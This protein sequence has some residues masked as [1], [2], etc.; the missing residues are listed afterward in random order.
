M[1]ALGTADGRN[2]LDDLFALDLALVADTATARRGSLGTAA[3]VASLRRLSDG[4][5]HAAALA[6]LLGVPVR[7]VLSEPAAARRGALTTPGARPDA[8]VVDLGAGTVDVIAVH[9]EVVAAGAGE[10]LT[11]A[12][13]ETLR[14]PRAAADWVKRGPCVRVDGGRRFEAEDGSRGFLDRPA[15]AAAAG[16]LAARGPAGLL[17]FDRGHSP[18]EWRAMRLRLKE[19]VFAANLRRALATLGGTLP[20]VLLVGGPAGDDELLGVLLRALPGDVLVGRATVGGT[21]A[22]P[23]AGHLY[24]AAVGLGLTA[25]TS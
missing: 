2:E 9:G 11:T 23:P 3:L 13:A 18:A 8:A 14:I 19:A 24:A 21:L 1:R 7:S 16:M 4:D 5:D 25:P 17:P 10:L 6:G 20:Q 22:G 12:V 15:P